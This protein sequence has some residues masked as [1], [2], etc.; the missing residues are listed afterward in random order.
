MSKS[1]HV[2]KEQ[3]EVSFSCVWQG[4]LWIHLAIAL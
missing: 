2:E 4:S 1:E 3:I